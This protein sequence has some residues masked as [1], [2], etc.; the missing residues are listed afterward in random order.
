[1]LPVTLLKCS[2]QE[3]NG[4]LINSNGF[5]LFIILSD[6]SAASDYVNI[7]K[8]S[9]KSFTC[10]PSI[11]ILLLFLFSI[12][13]KFHF[14]FSINIDIS[15]TLIFLFHLLLFSLDLKNHQVSF[16]GKVLVSPKGSYLFKGKI[17]KRH[18]KK[19]KDA[20]VKKYITYV[21]AP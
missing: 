5:F 21:Y 13:T 10:T 20:K 8:H 17:T 15:Y 19:H 16:K 14:L 18:S 9:L 4:I 12:L 7:L 6:P 2:H 11:F 1:M 3:T